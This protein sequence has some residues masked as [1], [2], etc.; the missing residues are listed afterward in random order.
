MRKHIISAII[1]RDLK[2]T[3]R[4]PQTLIILGI[5]IGI[6][7][8]MSVTIAKPLWVMTFAMS[9]VMVGFTLTSFIITEEKDKKTLEALLISP[10]TYSEILFG[11]LFLTLVLTILVSFGLIFSLHHS[12]IS[13]LHTLLSIP[14]GALIICMFGMVMGLVCP[15]Q[16]ALSGFGTVLML[17]LFL[18]ELLAS[19]NNLIGYLARALPTHHVIQISSLGRE[20]LSSIVL[21][22]YGMLFLS[23][24]ATTLWVISFVKTSAKQEGSSWKFQKGNI[25]YSG[26]LIFI[27]IISSILFIPY[28]GKIIKE[29]STSKY[30]N[31][32]YSISIPIDENKFSFKEYRIQDNFVTNFMLAS[33]EDDILYLSIKKNF[34]NRTREEDLEKTLEK[35][36]KKDALNLKAREIMLENGLQVAKVE[37]QSKDGEELFYLFNSKKFLYRFGISSSKD[38]SN[39]EL[40]KELLNEKINSIEVLD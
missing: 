15:T 31:S 32:E 20:G 11:K 17:I 35:L 6:N 39:L 40:L 5:T 1:K 24:F 25:T 26:L 8:F 34:K 4:N 14:I 33:S 10:A 9:L 37:Y 16:A 29:G 30:L 2:E 19:T 23:L 27:L 36:K 3:L 13:T 22:H 12:E 28:K 21:K 7:V 18:P 38:S